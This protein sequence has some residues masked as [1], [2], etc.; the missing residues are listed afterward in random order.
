MGQ[1]RSDIFLWKISCM[2]RIPCG[3]SLTRCTTGRRSSVS[4]GREVSRAQSGKLQR[5]RLLCSRTSLF[6]PAPVHFRTG[7]R[8]YPDGRRQ[9]DP[10][11]TEPPGHGTEQVS[12]LSHTKNESMNKNSTD[13][14]IKTVCGVFYM[15][16]VVCAE[17]RR[18]A[19]NQ[20]TRSV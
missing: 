5:H 7:D 6:C 18:S 11:S 12:A 10:G 9:E 13:C 16:I 1:I 14:L 2:Q 20:R 8:S 19:Q 4:G 17:T 15:H 3:A